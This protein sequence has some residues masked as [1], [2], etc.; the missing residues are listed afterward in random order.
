M[1]SRI[2]MI[3]SEGPAPCRIKSI[4]RT[5]L[6][7][8]FVLGMAWILPAGVTAQDNCGDAGHDHS[9]HA[10]GQ[11]SF[12]Q[13]FEPTVTE[14][15]ARFLNEVS[16][17]SRTNRNAAVTK[18]K[19]ALLPA[20]SPALDFALGCYCHEDG[21]PDE[22]VAAFKQAL[23]K[24]PL[25][26]RAR[27]NLA[28]IH[29]QEGELE[30][31]I[32]ELGALIDSNAPNK[33]RT[34]KLLAFAHISSGNP[35]AAETAYRNALVFTPDDSELRTGLIKSLLDQG[36]I[37]KT[38]A[39][40]RKELSQNPEREEMWSLL[41]NA[42]LTADKYF[43][44]MVQIECSRRLGLAGPETLLT[45]GDLYLD[46]GLVNEAVDLFKKVSA[47]KDAPLSRLL[48]VVEG[49]IYQN[50]L[51]E[52][53]ELLAL[54]DDQGDRQLST[55]E[56]LDVKLLKARLTEANGDVTSALT[57]YKELLSE[58]P[59]HGDS[60]MAAGNILRK[61]GALEDAMIYYERAERASP[62]HKAL[63]LVRQAQVAVEKE[64]YAKAAA[65]LKQS[66]E[67]DNQPHIQ[68][69]LD[70]VQKML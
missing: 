48:G 54:F 20:S 15:E 70:Q 26:H 66:L 40:I 19:S 46:Q 1:N 32:V 45:L 14:E 67:L 62:D 37:E 28:S 2:R 42:S 12:S 7:G 8:G 24:M 30:E 59:L 29:L 47:L 39:M 22:A 60:L 44:A 55:V 3:V 56:R 61:S 33:G 11:A 17:L 25:F 58:N 4:C 18:L 31:A 69:Y 13:A 16:T 34:W 51:G 35:F 64:D 10:N 9:S 57:L 23:E 53:A 43:E 41:A 5:M 21:R 36:D 65:W 6:L 68:N 50:R 63:A 52:A 49:F 27:S 38:S